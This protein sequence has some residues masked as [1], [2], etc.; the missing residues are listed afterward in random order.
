MK[1]LKGKPVTSGI[2]IGEALIFNANDDTIFKEKISGKDQVTRE[3]HRLQN[4]IKKSRGQLKKIRNNVS[5]IMGEESALI[6]QTQQMLLDDSKL[7]GEIKEIIR[8]EAVNAGWALKKI[9]QKYRILFSRIDD[10]AFKEKR[11]DLSDILNRVLDNLSSGD[12]TTE[13]APVEPCIVVAEDIPPSVAANLMSRGEILGL[14]LEK[15]GETSH[16]IILAK[17]LGIP[18]MIN[19]SGATDQISNRET[20]VVDSFSAEVICSPL[21]NQLTEAR[22]KQARFDHY[23]KRLKQTTRRKNKTRD[24]LTFRLLGNMEL[25]FEAELIKSYHAGGIGLFRTEFLLA[26]SDIARDYYQQT[27]IYKNIAQKFFP[28]E[29]VIRTFDVGRDK[30][31]GVFRH[32]QEENP[33]LG[34]MAVRLFL[35]EKVVLQTQLRALIRAN[36]Q[37]NLKILVPMITEIEEIITVKK[38]IRTISDDLREQGEKVRVPAFGIMIEVPAT[39]N[40]IESVADEVDFFSIGTNDLIQYMLAVDRNNSSVSY[41]YSPFHPAIVHALLE[42]REKTRAV[43]REVTVCGEMASKVFPAVMLLGMG[44]RIFSMDPMS[45]PKIKHIFTNI[46]FSRIRPLVK[47]LVRF[48]SKMEVEE[49]LVENLFHLYPSLFSRE[50]IL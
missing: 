17:T 13:Y 34:T 42:I 14:I 50:L 44:Y 9:E 20:L 1:I 18:T 39:I 8:E 38:M 31:Y 2:G 48:R 30:T 33:S 35:K 47:K 45:F 25:P 3:I 49:F 6:I 23:K 43:D 5:K 7:V 41:L 28:A 21:E 15:G 32:N 36:Q 27:L 19:V 12:P 29:V 22:I 24:D 46:S 26:G 16:A 11:N 37:G 10:L 4:A 40:M